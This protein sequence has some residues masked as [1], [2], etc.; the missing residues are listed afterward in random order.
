MHFYKDV[1]SNA[2]LAALRLKLQTEAVLF[3]C[4]WHLHA[5][6]DW[7]A[8]HCSHGDGGDMATACHDF[9][10][11]TSFS[12][13]SPQ[14]IPQSPALRVHLRIALSLALLR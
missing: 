9:I 6:I 1:L 10:D 14:S 2:F 12:I 8:Q 13:L 11:Y 3:I 4:L 7:S 5:C